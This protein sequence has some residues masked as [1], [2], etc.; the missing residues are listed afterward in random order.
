[1]NENVCAGKCISPGCKAPG[2][3]T[4]DS[5]TLVKLGVVGRRG[6]KVCQGC[7]RG[8]EVGKR[9]LL[10]SLQTG[11][12]DARSRQLGGDARRLQIVGEAKKLQSGEETRRVRT[13]LDEAPELLTV[14]DSDYEEE[15]ADEESGKE[16]IVEVYGGDW[17]VE[18]AVRKIANKMDLQKRIEWEEEER[19]IIGVRVERLQGEVEVT[20]G[21]FR[22][23]E[24]GMEDIQQLL[25]AE[26]LFFMPYTPYFHYICP[27]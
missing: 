9:Q 14:E 25:Y 20:K 10:S 3:T 4:A 24:R 22:D 8:V 11:G 19:D 17:Q 1:M 21:L 7:L 12:G 5:Y 27:G 6:G 13:E 26:V 18:E 16:D 15:V 23:L 2:E